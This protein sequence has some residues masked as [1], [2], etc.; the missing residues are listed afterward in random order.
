MVPL[1]DEYCQ[2][3]KAC[4]P[5]EVHTDLLF[6]YPLPPTLLFWCAQAFVREP[7]RQVQ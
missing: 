4:V 1:G 6:P 7:A 3:L 5:I 2:F